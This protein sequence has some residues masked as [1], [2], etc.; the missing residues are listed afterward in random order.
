MARKTEPSDIVGEELKLLEI[1]LTQERERKRE[2][3]REERR[4][5]KAARSRG[6]GRCGRAGGSLSP[7]INL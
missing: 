7:G 5:R 2:R 1:S 3:E 6:G 4:E